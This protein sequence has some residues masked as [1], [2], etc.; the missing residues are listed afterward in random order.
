[1]AT[2]IGK[3]RRRESRLGRDYDML[4]KSTEKGI[5]FDNC[6]TNDLGKLYILLYGPSETPYEKAV[7]CL[8]VTCNDDFPIQPP[9]VKCILTGSMRMHP[10]IYECGKI[11]ATQLN[12][13]RDTKFNGWSPSMSLEE[14]MIS[15]QSMLTANPL[16]EEPGNETVPEHSEANRNYIIAGRYLSL[17]NTLKYIECT[18]INEELRQ[19]IIGHVRKNKQFFE[20]EIQKLVPYNRAT[21]TYHLSA[22]SVQINTDMCRTLLRQYNEHVR[23][24]SSEIN[25]SKRDVVL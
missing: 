5:V 22:H 1:M 15:L 10:N 2:K 18:G 7:F 12:T 9:D 8:S 6:F 3:I 13:W 11:C 16:R 20:Q 23:T 19:L 24:S 14:L 17:L 21:I 4:S 25:C